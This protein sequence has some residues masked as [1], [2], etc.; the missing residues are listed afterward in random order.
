MSTGVKEKIKKMKNEV[1]D[2]LNDPDGLAIIS[3]FCV[4]VASFSLWAAHRKYRQETETKKQPVEQQIQEQ[5]QK[6]IKEHKNKDTCYVFYKL[7]NKNNGNN[8][9]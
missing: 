1:K 9:F 4:C 7:M 5:K 6:N 3:S 2:F 8:R